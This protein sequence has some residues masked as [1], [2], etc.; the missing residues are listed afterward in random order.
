MPKHQLLDG[1]HAI[2]LSTATRISCLPQVQ[3]G[4][5]E[6]LGHTVLYCVL[7]V[8]DGPIAVI[9]LAIVWMG[10]ESICHKD[11]FGRDDPP[12]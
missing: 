3:S 10:Y 11:R 1:E 8:G 2:Y 7:T 4:A 5:G 12:L 9:C 6:R